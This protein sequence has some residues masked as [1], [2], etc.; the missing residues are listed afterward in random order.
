MTHRLQPN[1]LLKK[2]K[3]TTALIAIGVSIALSGCSSS[4]SSSGTCSL[5]DNTTETSTLSTY[6]CPLLT[7]DV[8]S[9]Q[10][11][12][13]AQGLSGMW[14]KFSC[15]VTLTKSGSNVIIAADGQPDYKSQYFLS[16]NACYQEQ[17]MSGRTKNPNTISAQ[18]LTMTVP[19]SPATSGGTTT[20]EGTVGIAINGVSIF[21]NT[22]NAP[23]DIYTEALTF[24][25]CD[26]HSEMM[27][28][29]YHYH[30]EPVSISQIDDKFIGVLRDGN[31]IY[32]RYCNGGTSAP[33]LDGVG[34]HTATTIDST[35]TA[36]YH[37]H[38][39]LQTSSTSGTS[40]QTA[41][42]ITNGSYKGS[43]GS[44]TGC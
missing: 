22:A 33:T 15:R 24:D 21:D 8:S 30:T 34:G 23:D 2:T 31:P 41:W 28:S 16:S 14:L 27:Q 29:K 3:T 20:G 9:C 40:G 5:P 13:T 6:S 10:A 17:T 19:L 11:S 37:Y 26:G 25:K 36:V 12:R 18:S 38:V 1:S 32:G 43:L 44:C 39:N 7:R 4:S 42:F 35:S